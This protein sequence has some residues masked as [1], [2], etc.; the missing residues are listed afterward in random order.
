M[1]VSWLGVWGMVCQCGADVCVV[2][3]PQ[4]GYSVYQTASAERCFATFK[5][6]VTANGAKLAHP[7]RHP[8]PPSSLFIAVH[9]PTPCRCVNTWCSP[10]H[11]CSANALGS[12]H[13]APVH[14]MQGCD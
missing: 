6:F 1:Y 8:P 11:H 13:V 12:V 10:L 5:S 14:T 4:R 9:R 2:V 7:V 3:E